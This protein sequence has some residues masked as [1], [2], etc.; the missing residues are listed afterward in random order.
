MRLSSSIL[1]LIL[2]LKLL[3]NCSVGSYPTSS[4]LSLSRE[5]RVE[6]GARSGRRGMV[7]SSL[8]VLK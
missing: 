1:S 8:E 5:G 6:F 2:F 3:L 7:E 4:R